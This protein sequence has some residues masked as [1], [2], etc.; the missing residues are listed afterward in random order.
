MSERPTNGPAVGLIGCGRWGRHIL[1]DLLALGCRVPVVER[2]SPAMARARDGGADQTVACLDELPGVAALVVATPTA[3]HA[4]VLDEALGLGVPVFCEKPLCDDPDRAEALARRAEGRLF[5][6][7]KWRHH[8]AVRAL[9]DIAA[10]GELGA[11]A[12]LSTRRES[13]GTAHTDVDPIWTLAPHDLAAGLEIL[14]A[15]PQPR[16][17]S[18]ERVGGMAVGL[19]ARLGE[20][21]WL[22]IAVSG[23]APAHHR[24]MRLLLDEG[25]AWFVDGWTDHILVSPAERIGEEPERRALVGELPLLAELRAFVGFLRGGPPPPTGAATGAACVR[26]IADLRRMAGEPAPVS[27]TTG[28]P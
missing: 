9:R 4:D 1:R 21:P 13:W 18:L 10:S 14:G 19:H 15:L 26:L 24:S 20:R 3:T 17:A 7:D 12:G 28:D 11:P 25:V 8:P 5:V 2:S 22:E 23:A 27:V 16:Q 6:M